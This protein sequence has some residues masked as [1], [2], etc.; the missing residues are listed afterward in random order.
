MTS[1]LLLVVLVYGA[2]CTTASGN[3]HTDPEIALLDDTFG[4][5][6]EFEG[7][8]APHN[9]EI[10][11]ESKGQLLA[12]YQH[13]HMHDIDATQIFDH[14]V[15]NP[16]WSSAST[17]QRSSLL[18]PEEHH[19]I[20][21]TYM[22]ASSHSTSFGYAQSI[23]QDDP[24]IFTG[25]DCPNE[26]LTEWDPAWNEL[27]YD[28]DAHYTSQ[29]QASASASYDV[30]VPLSVEHQDAFMQTD[31]VHHQ[32]EAFASPPSPYWQALE[33]T[34]LAAKLVQRLMQVADISAASARARLMKNLN[35]RNE[36]NLNSTDP[37][38][39]RLA[40]IMLECPLSD[41]VFTEDEKNILLAN[42]FVR[43]SGKKYQRAISVLRRSQKHVSK[44]DKIRIR[45]TF[46]KD[47]ADYEWI[48]GLL[49]E[50]YTTH[51]MSKWKTRT[52][53]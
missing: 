9:D 15:Y 11:D 4:S 24:A 33:Q 2:S 34:N 41:Q 7:F 50:G 27:Q 52:F 40:L 46:P 23:D 45:D 16:G 48:A 10:R 22:P 8:F 17:S 36:E 3:P 53:R 12:Q 43:R 32:S 39:Q 13:D 37:E 1:L 14:D 6:S 5:L 30:P 26:S 44:E 20:Q 42:Y 18:N 38:R 35:R 29:G 21:D 49:R 47:A 51:N 31:P 19:Q 28:V 25:Q